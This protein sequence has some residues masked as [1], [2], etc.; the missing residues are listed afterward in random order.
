MLE[1]P[2]LSRNDG[3][4]PDGLTLFPWAGGKNLIWDYTNRDT[5]CASHVAGTSSEAGK[6]AMEAE[7]V[8]LSLY[9]DLVREYDMIP[10]ATETSPKLH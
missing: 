7:T 10:V 9:N 6:A 3:K 8:K 5:L 2:G 4:R 1:P